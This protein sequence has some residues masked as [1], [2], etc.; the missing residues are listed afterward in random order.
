MLRIR[1]IG[2]DPVAD[3]LVR[4]DLSLK[5][6]AE[7]LPIPGTFWGEPEAGVIGKSVYARLDT[8]V[9]SVFHEAGHIVCMTAERRE[10]LHR[11]A[12]GDDLEE[13][14]VC[15]LQVL[16]GDC[17]EGVGKD[18]LMRDMDSW[19]YSFRLGNTAAWF[20]SDADDARCWLV[21]H[22]LISRDGV[23]TFRLRDDGAS[24]PSMSDRAT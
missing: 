4:F 18:Q 6:V 13:S 23:P 5:L 24:P 20:A 7:D 19:G 14:A 21:D 11:D 10:T 17:L 15:Y 2:P 12:G 22:E 1:D 16:L 3:L 9:H 8:P